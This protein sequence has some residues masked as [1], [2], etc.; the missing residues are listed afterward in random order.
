MDIAYYPGCSLHASSSLYDV[1][2]RRIFS[3]IGIYLKEI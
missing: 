3:E 2:S 1:Q